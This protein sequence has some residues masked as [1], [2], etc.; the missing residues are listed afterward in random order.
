MAGVRAFSESPNLLI[1]KRSFYGCN[2]IGKRSFLKPKSIGKRSFS[3]TKLLNTKA[4]T[5]FTFLHS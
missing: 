2:F 3:D 1:G 5:K 4:L